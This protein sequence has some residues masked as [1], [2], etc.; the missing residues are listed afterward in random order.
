MGLLQLLFM[1][2][3][4]SI[5]VMVGGGLGTF[6]LGMKH[7]SEGLQAISG[8][9][10]ARQTALAHSLF[11]VAGTIV[12]IPFFV[13]V[14]LPFAT[15]FFPNYADAVVANGVTTYPNVAAEKPH[16]KEYVGEIVKH[17]K[18]RQRVIRM[19]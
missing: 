9:G 13:P 6:L 12:I 4:L 14:I 7:L 19:R 2:E 1:N 11:N 5:L 3:A 10:L 8:A 17:A 18:V 16:L 15:S